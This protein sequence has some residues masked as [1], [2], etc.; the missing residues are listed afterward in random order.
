MLF[1]SLGIEAMK[2]NTIGSTNSNGTNISLK[3]KCF[4]SIIFSM[5][6]FYFGVYGLLCAYIITY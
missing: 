5:T 3:G 1:N 2:N 4:W 6:L